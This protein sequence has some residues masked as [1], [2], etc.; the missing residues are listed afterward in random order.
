[1]PEIP[2]SQPGVYATVCCEKRGSLAPNGNVE[3]TVGCE[4]RR[5]NGVDY[6]FWYKETDDGTETGGTTGWILK[7]KLS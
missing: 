6:E 7:T 5:N 1:M 4:Y 2:T 3:G